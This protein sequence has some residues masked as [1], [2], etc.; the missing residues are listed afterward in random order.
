MAEGNVQD[1]APPP[2]EAQQPEKPGWAKECK[3]M[4]HDEMVAWAKGYILIGVGEGNFSSA[5]WT[6]VNQA[7]QRG[8][9]AAQNKPK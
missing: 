6:V 3:D 4:T 8:Y 5:V 1:K 2:D 9:Y 7:W